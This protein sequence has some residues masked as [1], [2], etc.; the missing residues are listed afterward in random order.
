MWLILTTLRFG[1][2]SHVTIVHNLIMGASIFVASLVATS[3]AD[4]PPRA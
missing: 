1:T 4:Y 3:A 2:A